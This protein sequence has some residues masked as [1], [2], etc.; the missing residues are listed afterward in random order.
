MELYNLITFIGG[1]LVGVGMTLLIACA[2]F[3]FMVW[4]DSA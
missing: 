3:A 4:K 1:V 2:A